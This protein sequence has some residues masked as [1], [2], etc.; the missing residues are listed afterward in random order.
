MS[1]QQGVVLGPPRVQRTHP[2][3]FAFFRPR[4]VS[5]CCYSRRLRAFDDRYLYPRKNLK[6]W[7]DE[8]SKVF[9]LMHR[10]SRNLTIVILHWKL[11]PLSFRS[12]LVGCIVCSETKAGSID[13]RVSFP[14]DPRSGRRGHHIQTSCAVTYQYC[15]ARTAYKTT[16]KNNYVFNVATKLFFYYYSHITIS[17]D[18]SQNQ[19]IRPSTS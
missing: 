8:Q 18:Q 19:S 11:V 9:S 10:D 15:L 13:W 17:I 16:G 12:L 3:V 14:S 5:L 4:A 2:V 7:G 1:R 6:L